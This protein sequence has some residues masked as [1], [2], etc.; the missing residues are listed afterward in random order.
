MGKSPRRGTVTILRSRSTI[1]GSRSAGSARNDQQAHRIRVRLPGSQFSLFSLFSFL[2]SADPGT[3]STAAART[4]VSIRMPSSSQAFRS[5]FKSSLRTQ[6]QE[7]GAGRSSFRPWKDASV[8][9]KLYPCLGQRIHHG[10]DGAAL[11][12]HLLRV[13]CFQSHD[14]RDMHL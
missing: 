1:R 9:A 11:P 10:R 4:I 3:C 6:W 8:L 12:A 2:A 13:E 5:D 7:K 14:S